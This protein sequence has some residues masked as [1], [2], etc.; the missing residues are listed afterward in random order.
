MYRTEDKNFRNNITINIVDNIID[1]SPR[2]SGI[3]LSTF[4]GARQAVLIANEALEQINSFQACAGGSEN[5][6]RKSIDLINKNLEITK[7]SKGHIIDGDFAVETTQLAISQI[8]MQNFQNIISQANTTKQN[9]L[10]LIK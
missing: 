7:V 4:K 5:R 3:N 2:L 8:F 1:N 10:A 6:L 9:F